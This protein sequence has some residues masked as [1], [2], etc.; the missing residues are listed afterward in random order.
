MKVTENKI[1]KFEKL[2]FDTSGYLVI[3]ILSTPEQAEAIRQ[4]AK[5]QRKRTMGIPL[6]EAGKVV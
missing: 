3:P 4:E 5:R 6:C 1:R 2:V